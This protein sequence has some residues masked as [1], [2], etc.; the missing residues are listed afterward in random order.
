M[1][2]ISYRGEGKTGVD[3][4]GVF[5]DDGTPRE[6]TS[7][8]ARSVHPMHT[9]CTSP[10]VSRWWATISTSPTPG[11]RTATSCAT[12]ARRHVPLRRAS[13][14]P[15]KHVSA[16]VHPFDVELGRRRPALRLVPGH[17]HGRRHSA[18]DAQAG[19]CRAAPAQDVSRRQ[20]PARNARRLEPGELPEVGEIAHA[21]D[22]PC[23][24]GS[25]GRARRARQAAPFGAWD[26]RAS[27]ASVR[28]R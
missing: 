10:A 27:Q 14:W 19:A 5:E 3:N 20:L 15:R 13:W 11:A 22:V 4:I 17:Q 28:R 16:M 25:Q 12:A 2:W 26:H 21:S 18:E 7:V 23:A 6:G 8:A 24:T 9:R 1:W